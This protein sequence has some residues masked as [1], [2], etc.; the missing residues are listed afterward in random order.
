MYDFLLRLSLNDVKIEAFGYTQEKQ[1]AVK[2][3]QNAYTK[4]KKEHNIFDRAD[5]VKLASQKINDYLKQFEKVYVDS[6]KIG[7]L[8]LHGSKVEIELLDKI[9]KHKYSST[10]RR[11]KKAKETTLFANMAFNAYDEVRTAIKIAK[12]LM[13]DGEN[14]EDI[15]IV[16]SDKNEYLPYYYTLLDEY[17][18]QGYDEDGI[19]LQSFGMELNALKFHPDVRVQKA[20]WRFWVQQKKI[21]QLSSHFNLPIDKERLKITLLQNTTVKKE[22]TGILFGDLYTLVSKERNYKHIIFIG[23]DITHF[24]KKAKDNFLYTQR[25]S[26]KHFFVSKPFEVAKTLYDELKK[27]STNLYIIQAEYK[28]KRKLA[29]S[30]VV[31]K[32]IPNSFDI[33]EIKS[34]ADYLKEQKRIVEP[35][36]EAYEQ[37]ISSAKFSVYD[38]LIEQRFTQGDKLSASAL[39]TY[40]K[41]PMQYYFANVLELK[42]PQDEKEGF[43][44]AQRGS[45]IH[46][47]FELFVIKA[48]ELQEADFTKENLYKFMFEISEEAYVSKEIQDAI[49]Y[50]KEGNLKENI[51]HKITLKE[52]QQGLDDPNAAQKSHLA[53]FVDYVLENRFEYFQNSHAEEEFMLDSEFAPLDIEAKSK[54]EKERIDK[55]KRFLKGFI[56]RLDNLKNEVNIIDY[57]S[58]LSSYS[59]SDFLL[60]KENGELKNFQLGLYMLYAKQRY[61][62]KQSYNAHLVSFKEQKPMYIELKDEKYTDEYEQKMKEQILQIQKKINGGIFAFDNSDEKVCEYCDFA[63][64]CHQAVLS[65]DIKND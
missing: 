50:D 61:P 15:V 60:D 37:S 54:E 25:E 39:N 35:E 27:L 23:A 19:V 30:I 17:G 14:E 21:I 12:K 49:G 9:K 22:R 51:N 32:K 4:Y 40:R 46:K 34:R 47:C 16:A 11:R 64:L 3:L 36:L 53:R 28:G 62:N 33:E 5:I 18:M 58:S 31:D 6:F 44:A 26:Q 43:D 48:K 41:C 38:G 29:P 7:D 63:T 59:R 20:F 10:I 56:D 45:L 2:K 24:P 13:L 55:E 8:T 65:K 52:I 42:A 57:K 1:K